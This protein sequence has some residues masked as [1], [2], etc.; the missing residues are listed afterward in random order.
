MIDARSDHYCSEPNLKALVARGIDGYVAPGRAQHPTAANG[1]VGGPLTQH[2]LHHLLSQ[3]VRRFEA[4]VVDLF[5][6]QLRQRS[7]NF[8]VCRCRVL[9]ASRRDIAVDTTYYER[10]PESAEACSGLRPRLFSIASTK[11]TQCG[12]DQPIATAPADADVELSVYDVREYH[13]LVFP[14]RRDGFGWRDMSAQR[15]VAL[16]PTHWRL[17]ES[18]CV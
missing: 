7:T 10:F 2:R 16:E 17:W 18:R 6:H 15:R 13:A 4:A 12:S 1:K 9:G 5:A 14:C 8:S 11:G 3:S